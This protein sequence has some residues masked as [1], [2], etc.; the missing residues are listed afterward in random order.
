MITKNNL[1]DHLNWLYKSDVD[2]VQVGHSVKNNGNNG[3][4]SSQGILMWN[5]KA[6]ALTVQKLLTV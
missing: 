1:V 4:V 2:V 5:I 3:K 6:L